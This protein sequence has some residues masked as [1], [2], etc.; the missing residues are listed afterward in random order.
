MLTVRVLTMAGDDARMAVEPSLSPGVFARP[1]DSPYRRANTMW[2]GSVEALGRLG[3]LG[4]QR[5]AGMTAEQVAAAVA[6]RHA[7][8]GAQVRADGVAF[9]LTFL[10]PLSLSWVWAQG[11]A[12][13]RADLE[14]AV[15]TAAAYSLDYLAQTRPVVDNVE[16]ARGFAAA[17]VLHVVGQP[18]PWAEVPTPLL[19]VHGYLVGVLNGSGALRG[20]HRPSMYENTLTR[21]CGAAGRAK[22]ADDLRGLG[23][24]IEV[25]TGRGGR[26]FEIEG[27]PEG[28]LCAGQSA[29]KGCAGLGE[30][31]DRDPWDSDNF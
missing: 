15:T 31:T 1:E 21:E 22:L 11:D 3:R 6:G 27:V 25:G 30:E 26:Y 23:F 29:D 17:L 28:L 7:V 9:D 2:V 10:A 12:A 4:L 24:D 13:L 18:Q 5:G 8:S 20:P 14:R 16:P 19:H